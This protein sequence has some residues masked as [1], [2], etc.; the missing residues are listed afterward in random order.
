MNVEYW[1]IPADNITGPVSSSG[2][3]LIKGLTITQEELDQLKADCEAYH[4]G[5][6][7]PDDG[8]YFYWFL[9]LQIIF[10]L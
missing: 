9:I 2:S 4:Q 1:S 5:E 8:E 3:G 10:F 7:I 6:V